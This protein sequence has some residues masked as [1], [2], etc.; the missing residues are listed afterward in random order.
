MAFMSAAL[1]VSTCA[2]SAAFRSAATMPAG[3]RSSVRTG[4]EEGAVTWKTFCATSS[5]SWK[6]WNPE[7]KALSW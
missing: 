3:P 7:R 1:Q 5:F 4:R 6:D 2:P